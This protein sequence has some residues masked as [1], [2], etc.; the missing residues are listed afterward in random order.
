MCTRP[1]FTLQTSDVPGAARAGLLQLHPPDANVDALPTPSYVVPTRRGGVTCLTYDTLRQVVPS[2][3]LLQL[4]VWDVL[5]QPGL[6]VLTK[7]NA[8]SAQEAGG[9]VRKAA[10]ISSFLALDTYPL[11][12]TVR[13]AER[14]RN[15]VPCTDRFLYDETPSGR[16]KLTSADYRNAL[17]QIRPHLAL[18]LYETYAEG[19]PAK[20]Q[21][22]AQECNAKWLAEIA[23]KPQKKPK[24]NA[25][26]PA[27]ALAPAAADSAPAAADSAPP[28][29]AGVAGPPAPG[30][31]APAGTPAPDFAG[32]FCPLPQ[33]VGDELPEACLDPDVAGY[34]VCHLHCGLA[35]A[36]RAAYLGRVV[37]LLPAAKPRLACGHDGPLEVLQLVA[38]GVDL[39]TGEYPLRE[40]LQGF[41]LAFAFEGPGRAPAEPKINLRDKRWA[42][43]TE[44]LVEGCGCVTCRRHSK[45]YVHHLLT[46]HEM[47]ADVL[48]VQHNVH[49]YV[50]YFGALRRAIA[51]GTL[52]STADLVRSQFRTGTDS[53]A[54]D[55][56]QG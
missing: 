24:T 33:C 27:P 34:A 5:D 56:F 48:L 1:Q 45:G 11:L 39:V 38:A 36:D 31:E 2:G 13:P 9:G 40:A 6:P 7:W 49:H 4:S 53:A 54:A 44:A 15:T 21:R 19:T 30:G 23:G 18:P 16:M 17:Q 10:G 46:T 32:L 29:A 14:L 55:A 43:C 25:A 37:P 28:P 51:D 50:R 22:R 47:T 20:R 41:A 26:G 35:E 3:S 52:E 42:R 12:L 8:G